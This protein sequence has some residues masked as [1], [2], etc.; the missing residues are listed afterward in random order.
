[1]MVLAHSDRDAIQITIALLL[2]EIN[3]KLVKPEPA[4]K[5]VKKVDKKGTSGQS[6]KKA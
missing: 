4:K 6:R 5:E 3:N 2:T 1:M